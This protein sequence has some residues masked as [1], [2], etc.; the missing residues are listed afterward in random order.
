[1]PDVS[2]HTKR[3]YFAKVKRANYKASMRLE[4]I[5]NAKSDAKATRESILARYKPSRS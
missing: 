4:G 2:L 3:T 5:Q 1:M